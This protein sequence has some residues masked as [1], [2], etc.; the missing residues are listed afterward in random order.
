VIYYNE[1]IHGSMGRPKS[2]KFPHLLGTP[3]RLDGVDAV[4]QPR[5]DH[6]PGVW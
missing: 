5:I 6:Q 2:D 1:P 4:A 3:L